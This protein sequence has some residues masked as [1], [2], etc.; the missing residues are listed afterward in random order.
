MYSSKLLKVINVMY[1][2]AI[3]L[4]TLNYDESCIDVF[5]RCIHT[6]LENIKAFVKLFPFLLNLEEIRD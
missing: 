3:Q 1:D 4:L 6:T 2:T 5:T